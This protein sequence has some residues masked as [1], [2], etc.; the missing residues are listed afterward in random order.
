MIF[1]N[2]LDIFKRESDHRRAA[3]HELWQIAGFVTHTGSGPT[4]HRVLQ[5]SKYIRSKTLAGYFLITWKRKA[6]E[7]V[8]ERERETTVLDARIRKAPV[9]SGGR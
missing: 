2:S 5:N 9:N 4:F 1:S 8:C 3:I 6:C 7:C